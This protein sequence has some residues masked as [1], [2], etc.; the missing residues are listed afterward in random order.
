[1]LDAILTAAFKSKVPVRGKVDQN[2]EAI[3]NSNRN[4]IIHM[5]DSIQKAKQ[6]EISACGEGADS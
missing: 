6:T 1:M 4:P 2:R 3:T 5:F